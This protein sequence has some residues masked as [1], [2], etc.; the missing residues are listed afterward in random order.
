MA[1]PPINGISSGG[2]ITKIEAAKIATKAGCHMIICDGRLENPLLNLQKNNSVFSWFL[3]TE[4][5]IN[6]R[7]QWISGGLH[8]KGQIIIDKGAFKA[9]TKGNSILAAGIIGTE[10]T[11]EKGDLIRVLDENKKI[12]GKGLIHFNNSEVNLIKGFKSENIEVILG[13]RGKDEVVHRD[14]FVLENY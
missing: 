11:Y 3:A 12:I 13:Y 14:D 8:I 6:A 2:M 1:G 5:P 4:K 10:G 9:V 7:K